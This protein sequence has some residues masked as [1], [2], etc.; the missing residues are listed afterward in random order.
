MTD[1]TIG[2][3]LMHYPILK[4][5]LVH[6]MTTFKSELKEKRNNEDERLSHGR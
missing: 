6:S 3:L 1:I 5:H 4:L 2:K